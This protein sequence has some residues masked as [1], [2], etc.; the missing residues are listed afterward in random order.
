MK[1]CYGSNGSERSRHKPTVAMKGKS[2]E[3]KRNDD[4]RKTTTKEKQQQKRHSG[5]TI[6]NLRIT[7]P[8]A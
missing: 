7:R 1:Y 6:G 4:K 2:Q 3:Q 5:T 8:E